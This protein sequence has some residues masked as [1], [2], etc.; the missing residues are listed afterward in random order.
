M[1]A[2]NLSSIL[3][4]SLDAYVLLVTPENDQNGVLVI[5]IAKY[6]FVLD[7]LVSGFMRFQ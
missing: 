5:A 3:L 4:N 2:F 1:I 6:L 7:R